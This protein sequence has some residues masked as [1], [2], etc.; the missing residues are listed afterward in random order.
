HHYSIFRREILS[1]SNNAEQCVIENPEVINFSFDN[2]DESLIAFAQQPIQIR[3]DALGYRI[4]YFL[5]S[6]IKNKND[7]RFRG[8]MRFSNLEPLNGSEKRSWR[9]NRRD[10][11]YGSFNHFKKS[12]LSGDIKKE[13]FRVYQLRNIDKFEIDKD[14]E[15]DV[16]DILVFKGDHYVLDF[17]NY[18]IVEFRKEKESEKFLRLS[19][20]IGLLY[21][22]QISKEGV[23]LH[24]PDNQISILKLLKGSVRLDLSGEIMDRFGITTYGYWSW[25][26]IA[27][28]VPI[29]YDPKYDNL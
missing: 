3:N 16:T 8:K 22:D 6:F 1:Q 26:R 29:N 12:L 27:D 24:Q 5:E 25:E 7:L 2:S 13:G 4:N 11:Y 21:P 18:L 20:Y 23:L 19:E 10:S 17:K 14:Q 9:R 28:L 15:L